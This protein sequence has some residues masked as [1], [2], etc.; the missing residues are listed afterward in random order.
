MLNTKLFDILLLSE[1]KLDD[2]I[3]NSFYKNDH[4]I[5]IR[6][7]RTRHGGG[8]LIFIKNNINVTKSILLEKMELIYFQIQLKNQKLNFV[9]SYRAPNLKEQ[10]FF[11]KLDDFIHSL[12]LND[13]LFIIGDLNM[14]FNTNYVNS[15][16]RDFT[17]NNNLVNYVQKPTRIANKFFKKPSISKSTSTL[18]DLLLHNSNLIDDS[19]VIDCPFSDHHIVV[20]KLSIKKPSNTFQKIKC[21]NL[22]AA[23]MAKVIETIDNTEFKLLKESDT[24]NDK[25][26]NFKNIILKIVDQVAPLREISLK[27]INQFPWY[28]EELLRLRHMKDSYYKRSIR[29]GLPED[30]EMFVYYIKLFND[31]NDEKMIEYFKDKSI[32]VKSDKSSNNPISNVNYKGRMTND[33]N[34]LCNVFNRFFASISSSSNSTMEEC[35]NF[36][37]GQFDQ[38]RVEE[39]KFKFSFTTANELNDLL[40]SLP[41]SSNPGICGIPTKILKSSSLKLRTIIAYLFNCSI[42]SCSIPNDWKTAIVLPLYKNKGSNDNLNNY[43]AISILPPMAKLFEKLIH[44]Q[45]LA[46][47]NDNNII[48]NDQHGFRSN[49]SCESALHEIISEINKIKSKRSIGLLL[50]IDFR[51]AFDSVDPRL[52][53]L[54]LTKIWILDDCVSDSMAFNLGVPQGSVL[55]PLLFLVFINDI[56]K[57]LS[58]FMVKL[59]ADDTT[60][61][62]SEFSCSINKLIEWCKFNRI[63]INWNKTKIMFLTNKRNICLP[64]SINVDKN[65][66]EVVNCFKL[67]GITIDNNLSFQKYVSEIRNSINKRL[68]SVERLFYLSDKNMTNTW[69]TWNRQKGPYYDENVVLIQDNDNVVLIQD[70]DNVVLIQDNDN[71][72]LIQ[73]NI[74]QDIITFT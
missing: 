2:S 45:I 16:I 19:D 20:A 56:V 62:I 53:L 28:D 21:R 67:L 3:P 37:D 41:S 39:T 44:K 58:D 47:L 10:Y 55:G 7:D 59:F 61:L 11:E 13:P 50:F 35:T 23:N 40:S 26:L 52:L 66:V 49:H 17:N 29:S 71:V 34:E 38:F 27:N 65:N 54:K 15:N 46:Y 69:N 31:Y 14:E 4:Y 64:K 70:N 73:D 48:T 8:L 60:I 68:Y 36:I 42:L 32:S 18:I 6:L 51:K 5:K 12:N 22:S 25:W 63:D 30:N 9:Y 24:I 74:I 33:K 1:T 43:R 72:V 57:Y